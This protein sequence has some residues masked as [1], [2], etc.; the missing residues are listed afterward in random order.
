MNQNYYQ[1]I[2]Y[3]VEDA[4]PTVKKGILTTLNVNVK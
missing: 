2:F 4:D 1:N 3:V